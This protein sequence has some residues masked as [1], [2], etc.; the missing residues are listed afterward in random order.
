MLLNL[1]RYHLKL[2]DKIF[3]GKKLVVA[4]ASNKSYLSL[5]GTVIDESKF[6]F[7]I[8]T[9]SGVKTVLK[10]GTVFVFDDELI[11]GDKIIKRLDER[12]KI[13]R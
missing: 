3:I 6:T 1:L 8:E 10:K 4:D 13:R 7:V 9:P 2:V 12:I 5:T 11:P